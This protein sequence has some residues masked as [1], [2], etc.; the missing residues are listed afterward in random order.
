MDKH[1]CELNQLYLKI[2]KR[3]IDLDGY[4]TYKRCIDNGMSLENISN[5]LKDSNEAKDAENRV[6][7]INEIESNSQLQL[8]KQYSFPE[9]SEIHIVISR[10][11]EDVN[12]IHKFNEFKSCKIFLYNKG[13]HLDNVFNNTEIIDIPN[14]CFEEYTYLTYI[15]Q[16]Y[17]NLPEHIIFMQCS[18]DHC[19][20]LFKNIC[21][22]YSWKTIYPLTESMGVSDSW[23]KDNLIKNI[24]QHGTLFCFINDFDYINEYDSLEILELKT[25]AKTTEHLYQHFC[26]KYHLDQIFP[27]F[28]I[29]AANFHVTAKNI[30]NVDFNIYINI[31]NDLTVKHKLSIYKRKLYCNMIERIWPTLFCQPYRSFQ[32]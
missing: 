31:I 2:F 4:K 3:P 13:E 10:Y 26:N 7:K 27:P 14:I 16:N 20:N 19:P 23:G 24:S 32:K 17:N 11:N 30:L 9:G 21:D 29:P 1:Y 18:L 5:I 22:I 15:T 8:T 6:H 12:W 25:L 28:Y